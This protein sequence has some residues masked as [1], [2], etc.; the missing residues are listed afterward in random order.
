M[1]YTGDHNI[2]FENINNTLLVVGAKVT[3]MKYQ[4]DSEGNLIAHL[5]VINAIDF[6]WTGSQL[7][8][9]EELSGTQTIQTIGQLLSI[10]QQ[11]G[12]V[13]SPMYVKAA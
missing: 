6:D 2:V 4:S 8:L 1:T 7:I 11:I 5:P 9:A 3:A 10:I 13:Y 12:K